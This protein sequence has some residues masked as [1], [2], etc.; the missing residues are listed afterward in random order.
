MRTQAEDECRQGGDKIEYMQR[1]DE[2]D[3]DKAEDDGDWARDDG[4]KARD[5]RDEATS[6][7]VH[8]TYLIRISEKRRQ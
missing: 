4:D 6:A 1:W 7:N 3:K 2:E 8:F 5:D